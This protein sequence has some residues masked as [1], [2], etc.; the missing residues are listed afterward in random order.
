MRNN[1]TYKKLVECYAF[2]LGLLKE[3]KPKVYKLFMSTMHKI[4]NKDHR[5]S[6]LVGR[7]RADFSSCNDDKDIEDPYVVVQ[8]KGIC[9]EIVGISYMPAFDYALSVFFQ[10]EFVW[11]GRKRIC[12]M[13]YPVNEKYIAGNTVANVLEASTM[14]E[15]G[16]VK[17]NLRYYA[18]Y[19]DDV[20]GIVEKDD[21]KPNKAKWC[22]SINKEDA[23]RL[24]EKHLGIF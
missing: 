15:N 18:G 1:E 2:S 11:G 13:L 7:L 24:D 9:K 8:N 3:F 17:K 4:E 23:N 14:D 19:A 20:L 21:D 22:C 16:E 5:F 6:R 12:Y 10:R